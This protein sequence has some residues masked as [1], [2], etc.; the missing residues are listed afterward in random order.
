MGSSSKCR[1]TNVWLLSSKVHSECGDQA[2]INLSNENRSSVEI[3]YKKEG[4]KLA[5]KQNGAQ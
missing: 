3:N 4:E 1:E 5:K 2:K